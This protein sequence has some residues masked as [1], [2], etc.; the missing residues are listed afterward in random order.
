MSEPQQPSKNDP[1]L[2]KPPEHVTQQVQYSQIS[3]RV[4]E[5]LNRGQ[6]ATTPVVFTGNQEFVCDFLLR[7]APPHLLAARVILPY[8]ALG[9]IVHTI[10][11]N[12]E[13]YRSRFGTPAAPPPPPPNVQQP[14]IVEVYEQLKI[15][16]EVAVGAYANTLMISHTPMEF[17]LD[18][19]LDLFPRPVVTQRI[20]LAAGQIPPFLNTLKR[21][22]DGVQQ[23]MIQL[24]QQHQQH[25]QQHLQHPPQPPPP[26]PPPQGEP[27]E[28]EA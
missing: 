3:A 8:S 12:L 11:E 24:Q 13:N 25:V 23:R 16:D 28:A 10:N 18:F 17:C 19:I 9:P 20:Y 7:M 22:L 4:P 15:S 2:P 26:P 1:N 6:F 5:K 21:T 14:N 27:T